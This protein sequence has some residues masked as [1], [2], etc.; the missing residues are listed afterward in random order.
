MIQGTCGKSK[1]TGLPVGATCATITLMKSART[2]SAIGSM[3]NI[4][5]FAQ[6]DLPVF[7]L[8]THTPCAVICGVI[9][10]DATPFI[11]SREI[12]EVS[13]GIVY[14]CL[15]CCVVPRQFSIT[16]PYPYRLLRVVGFDD[17]GRTFIFFYAAEI[18]PAGYLLCNE[19]G[20]RLINFGRIVV[21]YGN[22][23]RC[24]HCNYEGA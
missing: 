7:H 1:N 10:R 3:I 2:S 11:P 18:P 24:P 15:I 12:I 21:A 17:S 4:S 19:P 5:C 20:S 16:R 9:I 13:P 6:I 8:C 14:F 23:R 22:R